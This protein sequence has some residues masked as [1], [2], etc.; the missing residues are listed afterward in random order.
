MGNRTVCNAKSQVGGV[1]VHQYGGTRGVCKVLKGPNLCCPSSVMQLLDLRYLSFHIHC[2]TL[3]LAYYTLTHYMGGT[4]PS[5]LTNKVT[6]KFQW[7]VISVRGNLI[8]MNVEIYFPLFKLPQSGN[9][10]SL[11]TLSNFKSYV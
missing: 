8:K 5:G 9:A 6:T 10:F 4:L 1:W 7:G 11:P 2:V 3:F